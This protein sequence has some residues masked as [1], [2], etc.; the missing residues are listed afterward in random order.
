MNRQEMDKIWKL[1]GSLRFGDP[2]ANDLTVKA[3]W[4]L[5]LE[6]YD[7]KAVMDAVLAHFRGSKYFPDVGEITRH[8]PPLPSREPEAAPR[9]SEDFVRCA[10]WDIARLKADLAKRDTERMVAP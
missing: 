8:L 3:A 1:I 9:Y 10:R 7:Y 5:V 6:P 4:G 2:R